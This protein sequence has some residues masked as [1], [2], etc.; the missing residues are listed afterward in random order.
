MNATTPESLKAAPELDPEI[1][2]FLETMAA[3]ASRYPAPESMPFDE[4]RRLLEQLRARWTAGGPKMA[5]TVERE[6]KGPSG[7]SFRVRVHLPGTDGGRPLLVYLHG[8]GWTYFSLDTHDRLMREYAARA[9]AVVVG[10][11][12][13]LSP[14]HKFPV[15]LDQLV[16]TIH[17]L[18]SSAPTFGADPHRMALGGDSAGANL[19]VAAALSLRDAGETDAV[20]GLVL[21]YGAFD[22]YC[23]DQAERS[24]GGEGYMLGAE[25]MRRFWANY[26]REPADLEDPLVCPLRA[27]LSGLPPSLLVIPQCDLLTEQNHMMA[28]KLRD[29][30]VPV[31]ANEYR[32]ATHS[33]L[34]AM[35]VAE[36]SRR[37]LEDTARWL[38]Q[39]L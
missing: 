14:E 15:A 32:G 25:E 29:A 8:G 5:A 37:A 7:T 35:S 16:D 26:V 28:A 34:E 23:S 17:W 20:S 11:D 38:K 27:D 39:Q 30:G 9:G 22:G 6:L 3:D 2:G 13:A 33:F 12:Y 24:Y 4:A 36:V 1:R 18:Q 10:V 21:N 31:E 19:A